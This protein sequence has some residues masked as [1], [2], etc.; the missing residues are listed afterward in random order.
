[1]KVNPGS[2][3]PGLLNLGALPFAGD[4]PVDARLLIFWMAGEPNTHGERSY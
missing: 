1:M 2:P 4:L 3:W